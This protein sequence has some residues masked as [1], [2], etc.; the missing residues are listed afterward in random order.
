MLK[1]CTCTTVPWSRPSA[2]S[3]PIACSACAIGVE[4]SRHGTSGQSVVPPSVGGELCRT[5]E[6]VDVGIRR[7]QRPR[8]VGDGGH[9]RRDGTRTT[10][11]MPGP[12]ARRRSRACPAPVS[13]NRGD[14][15]PLPVEMA[16]S[17]TAGPEPPVGS[18]SAGASK[19]PSTRGFSMVPVSAN[20]PVDRSTEVLERRR[21]VQPEPRAA[22][23]ARPTSA[24]V[25]SSGPVNGA[26]A[27]ATTDGHRADPDTR[28][29]SSIWW[30]WRAVHCPSSVSDA[31][32]LPP[33]A[34]R[35]RRA[36]GMLR[37]AAS[38]SSGAPGAAR[39][40]VAVPSSQAAIDSGSRS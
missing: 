3:T 20:V 1:R 26:G 17:A 34:M 38:I 40:S 35:P 22:R 39:L 15:R 8:E 32:Q 29:P 4:T 18:D 31:V 11:P 12:R 28:T 5:G 24:T 13:S 30:S 10:H 23:A 25:T 9:I 14:V 7:E 36:S 21:D 16:T 2:V 27:G 6:L 37:P 33:T 19:R